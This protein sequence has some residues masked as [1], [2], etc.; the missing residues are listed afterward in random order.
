MR[1]TGPRGRMPGPA[2]FTTKRLSTRTLAKDHLTRLQKQR[3][4]IDR[5]V[6]ATITLGGWLVLVTLLLLIW[7]LFS[8]TRPLLSSPQLTLQYQMSLQQEANLISART[9]FDADYFYLSSANNCHYKLLKRHFDNTLESWPLRGGRSWATGQSETSCYRSQWHAFHGSNFLFEINHNNLLRAWQVDTAAISEKELVFSVRLPAS[10]QPETKQP[11]QAH[12]TENEASLLLKDVLGYWHFLRFDRITREPLAHIRNMLLPGTAP[13]RI[14]NHNLNLLY[15]GQHLILLQPSDSESQIQYFR[16]AELEDVIAAVSLSTDR[17]VLLLD[18]QL[19]AEKWSVLNDNGVMRLEMLY[20][21]QLPGKQFKK[22]AHVS[23]DLVLAIVDDRQFFINATTGE[24]TAETSELPEFDSLFVQ[25]T[26]LWGQ[27]GEVLQRWRVENPDSVISLS[28]LWAEIWYDGYPEPDYVWQTTSA[29]DQSQAKYSLVPLLMG[30]IKAAFLA[31]IVA[32]PLAIGSAIYTAYYAGPKLRRFLKPYIEVLEAVPSVVIGFLAAIWLLPLS[33]SYLI[34]VLLFLV[35][36]PL[37]LLLFVWLNETNRHRNIRAWELGF[38]SVLILVFLAL[39]NA[40]LMDVPQWMQSL[41]KTETGG[42]LSTDLKG[43]FV[44]AI[45]MGIAIVPTVFTIAEDAIYQVP[46]SLSK[47]S[48]AMGASRSQTLVR[49]VL[50]VALPGILSAIMLGFAR[51]IGE[52]MIVLMVSGNTPVADW[53]L[54]ESM[55]TMTA[56][57]AIELPEA[58]P[59]TVHYQV[60]FLVASL[61]FLFTFVF[62]TCAEFLRI[63]LRH[64]YQL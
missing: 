26:D 12:L 35:L 39:F 18:E 11:W 20:S 53:S 34:A 44:L 13:F 48:F 36:S 49:I 10:I 7:H 28:S 23:G 40:F 2:I 33:E 52:T 5:R 51:A 46:P 37:F 64:R 45:A 15:A 60:L 63:K 19:R 47:A 27:S 9:A 61:L 62:N 8:V 16:S 32:I 54:L 6:T 42:L 24:I 25:G 55:R 59:G 1:L 30:S 4:K 17:S 29:S 31:I 43:T 58:Q 56:N 41:W 38:F 57:L 3:V 50:K 21:I 14:D 22:L